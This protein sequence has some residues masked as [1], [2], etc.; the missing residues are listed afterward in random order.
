MSTNGVL[1]TTEYYNR[2]IAGLPYTAKLSPMYLE[3]V[4]SSQISYGKVKNPYK[5]HFRVGNSGTWNYGA[6]LDNL[7]EESV[8]EPTLPAGSPVPFFSG[9]RGG[10]WI[11]TTPSTS[12][13]FWVT[14]DEP[15]PLEILSLTIFTTVTICNNIH[16]GNNRNTRLKQG[17]LVGFGLFLM[18]Y[19]LLPPSIYISITPPHPTQ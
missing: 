15:L 8:R 9:D 12:P 6:T 7:T 19:F 14:S 17:D 18:A 13:T 11:S 4:N 10:A 3:V 2:V 1:T 16:K 5:V